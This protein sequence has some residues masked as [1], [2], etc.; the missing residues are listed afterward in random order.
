MFIKSLSHF[1]SIN[2]LKRN[3][4]FGHKHNGNYV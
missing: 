3:S 4:S 2:S 1:S